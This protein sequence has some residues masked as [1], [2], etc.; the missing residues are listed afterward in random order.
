MLILEYNYMKKFFNIRIY[1]QHPTATETKNSKGFSNKYFLMLDWL[2]FES[3]FHHCPEAMKATDVQ[4]KVYSE[5]IDGEKEVNRFRTQKESLKFVKSTIFIQ[6]LGCGRIYNHSLALYESSY[7]V[8]TTVS[9]A[10]S[11]TYP[12]TIFTVEI[13]S[14]FHKTFHY[15]HMA[16]VSCPV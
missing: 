11:F 14:F 16:T 5:C 8:I 15:V 3:N 9:S 6:I 4:R 10:V 12:I 2:T 7:R 13:S 1:C